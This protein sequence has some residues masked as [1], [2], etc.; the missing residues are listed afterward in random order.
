MTVFLVGA[1]PGS[2]DLLTVKA[3]DLIQKA[4]CALV[5]ALASDDIVSLI[6]PNAEIIDVGKNPK[7]HRYSQDEINEL[8]V[9][10][11]K[12][13][14]C[15][16]RIKGGDP[17]IFGRGG[18]EQFYLTS[19]GIKCEVVP[20]I[21]SAFAAP[22]YAGI[23][24]THRDV[25]PILTVATGHEQGEVD[26]VDWLAL[27]ASN[28]PLIIL[29]G[30]ANRA[31]ISS[32]LMEGGRSPLEPVAVITNAT[33][34][35]QQVKITYLEE[36]ADLEIVSPSVI[37]VGEIVEK[38]VPW[39][40]PKALSGCRVVV[41]RP[42][43]RTSVLGAMLREAGASVLEVSPTICQ[44]IEKPVP[45]IEQDCVLFT[46]TQGVDSFLENL[47]REGK[48]W[49]YLYGKK[50]F[51]IGKATGAHLTEHGCNIEAIAHESNSRG[52]VKLVKEQGMKS[53]F[54]VRPKESREVIASELKVSGIEVK[55]YIVYETV[56]HP[57][58]EVVQRRI[59]EANFIVCAAGS[60]I[61]AL[62]EFGKFSCVTIGAETTKV[63]REYGWNV[64]GQAN[65]T[66]I[67]SLYESVVEVWGK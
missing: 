23:P 33:R 58:N 40:E 50:I 38:Q 18:E 6:N 34:E 13:Y 64:L 55:E 67:T 53:V 30:V 44:T 41:A 51:A 57:I 62:S 19:K 3:R 10:K 37:V 32:K 59:N 2:L 56:A 31:H 21:S 27:G 42:I 48:D 61:R 24:V 36:L 43:G 46:S 28:N 12:Q 63:A 22:A 26:Q 11:A 29:M 7:K 54:L 39:F 25:A 14:E 45:K 1:G 65:E 60:T 8:L 16:V 52:C 15:I 4:D 66:S 17:F 49:R 20:G 5:D 35:N 47:H 9:E